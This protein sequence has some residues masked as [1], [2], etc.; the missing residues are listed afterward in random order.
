MGLLDDNKITKMEKSCSWIINIWHKYS[1]CWLQVFAKDDDSLYTKS[2]PGG[3]GTL[4][5]NGALANETNLNSSITIN[6]IAD[7]TSNTFVIVGKNS[8]IQLLKQLQVKM[9][10]GFN[11]SN[12]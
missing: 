1:T 11:R 6:C 2:N 8:E 4:T 5:L 9:V 3:A 12:F 10:K 7:E